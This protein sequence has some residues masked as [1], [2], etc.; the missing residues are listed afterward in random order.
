MTKQRILNCKLLKKVIFY[1][2]AWNKPANFLSFSLLYFM[3][4]SVENDCGTLWETVISLGA[5]C[6]A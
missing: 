6:P 3:I 2:S 5:S 1:S 4:F